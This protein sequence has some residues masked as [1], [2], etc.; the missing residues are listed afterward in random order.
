MAMNYL[1]VIFS[2]PTLHYNLCCQIKD[3][4]IKKTIQTVSIYDN[5]DTQ[6]V[7]SFFHPS[8]LWTHKLLSG[9]VTLF[10]YQHI[11]S[12]SRLYNVFV[13]NLRSTNKTFFINFPE[14]DTAK[15]KNKTCDDSATFFYYLS[16]KIEYLW[17]DN[18]D[19]DAK[20]LNYL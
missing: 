7:L 16:A 1:S 4:E 2:F 17:H 9:E 18:T 12:C 19:I 6:T 8:S 10:P 15:N 11:I 20:V 3:N 13:S 5:N 14:L